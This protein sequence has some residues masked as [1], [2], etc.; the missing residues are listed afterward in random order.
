MEQSLQGPPPEKGIADDLWKSS[1]TGAY[2]DEIARWHKSTPW[3][4]ARI[5]AAEDR[6]GTGDLFTEALRHY[7]P[8]SGSSVPPIQPVG[9]VQRLLSQFTGGNING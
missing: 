3:G 5:M 1:F 8:T 7:V 2:K 6:K 9:G 4:R